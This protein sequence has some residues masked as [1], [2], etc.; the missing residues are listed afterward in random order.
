[1]EAS[2]QKRIWK[3]TSKYLFIFCSYQLIFLSFLK[4]HPPHIGFDILGDAHGPGG[5]FKVQFVLLPSTVAEEFD[6]SMC[7]FWIDV[8]RGV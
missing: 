6:F 2:L 7:N 4:F 5:R 1:M 8:K 3:S